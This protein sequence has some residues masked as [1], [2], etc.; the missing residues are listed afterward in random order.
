MERFSEEDFELLSPE[1]FSKIRKA[2][3]N[4]KNSIDTIASELAAELKNLNE[5]KNELESH[6]EQLKKG[7]MPYPQ[8]A[9]KLKQVIRDELKKTYDS[10]IPV[11]F[12]ADITVC[13]QCILTDIF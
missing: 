5:K 4:A 12:L 10:D 9:E 13:I 3:L 2:Y 7:I 11:D 6:I 1:Y 8:K